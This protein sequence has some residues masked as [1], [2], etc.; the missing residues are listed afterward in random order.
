MRKIKKL[1]SV[2][3]AALLA[4]SVTAVSLESV[5]AVVDENG[6][7][8]PGDN[9]EATHRYYFAMPNS[10][11]NEYTD[12]AGVYWWSGIDACGAVD[13]TGGDVSWPGYKAHRTDF[14]TDYYGMYYLDCPADVTQI[15]W[16]N[17]ID[18]GEDKYAPV[19]SAAKQTN[20]ARADYYSTFEAYDTDVYN[21][22]WF[23]EMEESYNGDKSALGDYA[24]NFFYDEEYDLGFSFNFDN[25]I[26]VAPYAPNGV[27]FIGK[28]VYNGEWYFYYGDGEYGTYP[29]REGAEK[30]GTLQYLGTLDTQT[31]PVESEPIPLD[32]NCGKIYFDVKK[33]G[34]N[35]NTNK[36]FYCHIWRADGSGSWP[37][38]QTK[39]ELCTI[40]KNTGIASYDLS[41]TGNTIN[42]SDGAI[43]C[44]IFSSNTG[45]QTYNTI[46]SG[47]CIGDT[48][49]CTGE[50]FENPNDSEKRCMDTRWIHNTNLGSEKI[51]TSTGH[52]V[53]F[54]LP[55]SETDESLLANYLITYYN[56]TEKTDMT[57]DILD[58]L[59]VSPAVVMNVVYERTDDSNKLRVIKDILSNCA[60]PT[61][62]YFNGY[63]YSK[64]FD[65]IAEIIGYDG[66]AEELIIPRMIDGYQINSIS[67]SAFKDC[68]TLKS[69]TIPNSITS[70]GSY[71]FLNCN[72]LKSITIPSSVTDVGE[73][74]FGFRKSKYTN[75]YLRTDGFTILGITGSVAEE[76]ASEA[77]FEFVAIEEEII[78]DVDGD[79][80][81]SV[82]DV[83]LI[84]KY[85]AELVMFTSDQ[86]DIA[87]VDGDTKVSIFDATFIQQLLVG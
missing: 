34:W 77:G 71:A 46:M 6:C 33:S 28:P 68:D 75:D 37:E 62:Y 1:T 59:N 56:D 9:V 45:M 19:Y 13:G 36:V 4:C 21:P 30:E 73:Y 43:Y 40:D 22:E 5:S 11:L 10:W 31:D 55:D 27:N 17:Y 3:L 48:L 26:F 72:N 58:E 49:Y 78:G 47:K 69:V 29:T 8:V 80:V 82:K 70:V 2:F 24:D 66:D 76:Y 16:N 57:Q 64:K 50:Q 23:E 83:T 35:R 44:V 53:G 38:W 14:A 32:N 79:G 42:P 81:L 63:Y 52:V 7:Y 12:T 20:D 87:N 86:I 25:M 84:Q 67:D 74:A 41:K 51:I 39:T 60:D 85:L 54:A 18:G 15:I 65:G 61:K